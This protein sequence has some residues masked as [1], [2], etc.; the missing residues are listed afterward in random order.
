MV[1]L[2]DKLNKEM[3]FGAMRTMM[4]DTAHSRRYTGL[5]MLKLV[6]ELKSFLQ[7]HQ[8]GPGKVVVLALENSWIYPLLEQA[9]WEVGAIAHPV[10][11]SSGG[12]EILSALTEFG[13]EALFVEDSLVE[14]FDKEIQMPFEKMI[15][16]KSHLN[17]F[18]SEKFLSALTEKP[19]HYKRN[20]ASDLALILNTS[21]STGKPK[22]VGLTFDQLLSSAQGIIGSQDLTPTDTC[23]IFMPMFHVNAQ[24]IQILATRLSGGKMVV[25][26]RF[27]ASSFW[28]ILA[29]EGV[30]WVSLVP[31]VVQILLLN[32]GARERFEGRRQELVVKYFRSASFSLAKD[33]L[34]NFEKDFAIK[35]REG[36]GMTESA[37]LIALNP[38][39]AEK[40]GTVGL[41][42]ATD[43]ALLVNGKISQSP[44]VTGEILLRGNHVISDY[45]DSSPDSFW[46]G[47]LRTGDLGSFDE[48][49]Y[50]KIM[51]RAKEIINHGG[52]KVAPLAIESCLS[53]LD[54]VKEVAVVGLPDTLYG[55]A[56][57]AVIV[58]RDTVQVDEIFLS[59]QLFSFAKKHL[60]KP[61]R[62]TQVYFVKAYP[63][64]PT[65]KIV[66]KKLVESLVQGK[67]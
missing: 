4:V 5:E 65:G 21:G 53:Q 54:F 20:F 7:G 28:D 44:N 32:E 62:P 59:H 61:K 41:P 67:N 14:F 27:S 38:E 26:P 10:A 2:L 6:A 56:V 45:L 43:V 19:S 42:V 33:I 37:S 52:E 36:Y 25:A 46:A 11:P 60:S 31:T 55:E 51:G 23:L 35:I 13:Y 30:T 48:D 1:E 34:S 22:R 47:W 15:F 66:R 8:I 39:N 3:A 9:V 29:S 40:A 18:D 16:D 12:Q 24:V 64:N 50:L 49:G 58:K 57:T 17:F 63:R